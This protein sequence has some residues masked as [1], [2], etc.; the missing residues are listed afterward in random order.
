MRRLAL[1]L[2]LLL[3]WLGIPVIQAQQNIKETPKVEWKVTAQQDPNFHTNYQFGDCNVNIKRDGSGLVL[4]AMDDAWVDGPLTQTVIL[5]VKDGKTTRETDHRSVAATHADGM[6]TYFSPSG[7]G[8]DV[9]AAKCANAANQLTK[10]VQLLFGGF[11]S[12][13]AAEQQPSL[14]QPPEWQANWYP[15]NWEAEK[16]EKSIATDTVFIHHTAWEPNATWQRLSEEQKKRLYDTRYVIADKDPFVQGQASHSGH[17]RYVDGKLVEV[18]Y[19]YHV[20]VRENG[21][22]VWL[23][24]PKYVG[25]HAGG[26][27][28][29][30]WNMRSLA[31][32]LD[33]DFSKK[34]P[35][36]KM[37]KAAAKILAQWC[38]EYPI[39]KLKA[40]YDVRQTE[41][42]G[43]W[44]REKD[45]HGNTGRDRL[46]AMA[47]VNL[48]E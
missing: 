37:L 32:V 7:G 35:P 40:H 10:D 21:E 4:S 24:D 6:I 16:I 18:F 1:L 11:Y 48:S 25:W 26:P 46:M 17:Y 19:G 2:A 5:V 15:I 23:L 41:C 9:F 12:I 39:T 8:Y 22:I 42:P 13:P 29:W 31:I 34:A 28:G 14:R 20:M 44:Y 36:K 43:P 27:Q 30:D 47:H 38:K 3:C 45:K 33:G